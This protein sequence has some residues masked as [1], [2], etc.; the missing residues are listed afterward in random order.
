[1][2]KKIIKDWVRVLLGLFIFALGLQCTIRAS[3]G[4]APWDML[5]MGLSWHT[6]FSYGSI[7]AFINIAV[8][9]LDI[10]MREPI[11]FGTLFD[12]FL[13]G[14]F[15]DF[16][17]SLP[18]PL[19]MPP[20]GYG[21]FFSVLF[22]IA[23]LFIMALGQYFYM[24]AAQGCGPRDAFLIGIGKHLP[25]LPIGTVQI[26]IQAAIFIAGIIAGGPFGIG[27]A[28]SVFFM[29][30]TMQIVFHALRFEPRSVKSYD[31]FETIKFFIQ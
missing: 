30:G 23:G 17:A 7:Y 9:V 20:T 3:I 26:M 15:V 21:V 2:K 28:V 16:W 4:I 5:T 6:G 24:S 18:V 12:A 27:T 14:H 29:G 10:T 8:L 13:T 25:M 31:L 1:M 19:K 22:L 11:G